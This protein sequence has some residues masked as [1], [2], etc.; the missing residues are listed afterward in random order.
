MI[1]TAC[2]QIRNWNAAGLAVPPL[3]INLSAIQ[4]HHQSIVERI[5]AILREMEVDASALEFEITEGS[6]M[7]NTDEVTSTLR[8]LTELGLR[9]AIDDFGTGYSSLGYLKHLPIE[10][11]KIDRIFVMDIHTNADDAAIVG[12][13]ISMAHSLKLRV[14]AEGVE[15]PHQLELL[16]ELNCDQ[17][18]GF[19]ASKPLSATEMARKLMPRMP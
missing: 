15:T 7:K 1:R 18:Q 3:A 12:A 8:Q 4:V 5:A 2:A 13:M 17:Y 11:L 10:T 16:R 6:L 9:I 14:T 19:L